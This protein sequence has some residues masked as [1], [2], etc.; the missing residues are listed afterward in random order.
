MYKVVKPIL[1]E[2]DVREGRELSSNDAERIR[3]QIEKE[4][5]ARQD[6]WKNE[7]IG[8]GRKGH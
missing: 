7:Q 6:A 4:T 1:G 3:Q 2:E 5:K 8:K